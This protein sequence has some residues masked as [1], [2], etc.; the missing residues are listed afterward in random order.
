MIELYKL[1]KTTNLQINKLSYL[2]IKSILYNCKIMKTPPQLG[3]RNNITSP[4]AI[5]LLKLRH[6]S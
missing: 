6:T 4:E 3:L 1:V 5:L 2:F